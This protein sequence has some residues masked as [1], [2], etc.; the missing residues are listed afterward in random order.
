MSGYTFNEMEGKKPGHVLQGQDTDPQTI[1]DI[2]NHLARYEPFYD[3]ILNYNKNG[4]PYWISLSIN[5][6]W[7]NQNQLTHVISVQ[8]NI[9]QVKQTCLDFTRKLDAIGGALVIMEIDATGKLDSVNP[10]FEEALGQVDKSCEE[11]SRS[12]YH[13]ITHELKEAIDKQGYASALIEFDGQHD[14]L[15]IDARICVLKDLSGNILNYVMFGIDISTR[16][17]PSQKHKH[18]CSPSLSPAKRS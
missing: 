5:P 3:G 9:T 12:I 4:E 18:Q 2:R 8:A 13:Q 16:V 6:V 7:D 10:L 1:Q 17:K 15:A 11:A 14:Q